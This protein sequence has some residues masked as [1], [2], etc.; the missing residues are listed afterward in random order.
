MFIFSP[1][2]QVRFVRDQATLNLRTHNARFNL[3]DMLRA[4]PKGYVGAK[5]GH[6]YHGRRQQG[7]F[8]FNPHLHAILKDNAPLHLASL[9]CRA[10]MAMNA[11]TM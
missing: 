10:D 6:H 3:I 8:R 11:V 4:A 9:I 7:R 2:K 5:G 1:F